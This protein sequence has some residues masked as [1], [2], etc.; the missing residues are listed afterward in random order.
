MCSLGKG[1]GR[2]FLKETTHSRIGRTLGNHCASVHRNDS[3][4]SP[5]ISRTRL[6]KSKTK[7]LKPR[8]RCLQANLFVGPPRRL[9]VPDGDQSSTPPQKP[10]RPIGQPYPQVCAAS[11]SIGSRPTSLWG[12]NQAGKGEQCT[13][14]D[15]P[16]PRAASLLLPGP[17]RR[18][19]K[20]SGAMLTGGPEMCGSQRADRVSLSAGSRGRGLFYMLELQGPVQLPPE[21][22]CCYRGRSHGRNYI[23]T[24]TDQVYRSMLVA[25][26][27]CLPSSPSFY[28]YFVHKTAFSFLSLNRRGQSRANSEI[29]RGTMDELR[30]LSF[31]TA[32]RSAGVAFKKPSPSR[33]A[34]PGSSAHPFPVSYP[35]EMET[36]LPP[37]SGRP[38]FS[39]LVGKTRSRPGR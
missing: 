4:A 27:S 22:A 6:V 19:A 38:T 1:A 10:R 3:L 30:K 9:G 20:H 26:Q 17:R 15:A 23:S 37:R 32:Q 13:P 16:F 11:L 34:P 33:K 31:F 5:A 28:T 12:R 35:F 7:T 21:Y 36:T 29:F 8:T 39:N 18:K 25:A 14:R 24:N 2:E